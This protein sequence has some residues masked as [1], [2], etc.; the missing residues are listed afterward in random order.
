MKIKKMLSLA[1]SGAMALSLM[2]CAA[3]NNAAGATVTITSLNAKQ[4]PAKLEVPYNPQRIAI[5]S[6]RPTPVWTICKAISRTISPI[7]ARSRKPI[8]RPSWPVSPM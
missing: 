8:W 2:A 3:Q 1:L 4:E 7:W 6:A 5:L